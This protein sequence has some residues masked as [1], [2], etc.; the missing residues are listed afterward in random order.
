MIFSIMKILSSFAFGIFHFSFY[1]NQCQ[2]YNFPDN[3]VQS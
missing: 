1:R 2:Q 3:V